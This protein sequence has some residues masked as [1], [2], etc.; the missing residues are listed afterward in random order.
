MG[1]LLE[2]GASARD[3]MS[4]YFVNF[5]DDH[6]ARVTLVDS[7]FDE[8][9]RSAIIRRPRELDRWRMAVYVVVIKKN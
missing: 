3:F 2:R 8:R 9:N 6:L 4:T 1:I 7:N 5:R